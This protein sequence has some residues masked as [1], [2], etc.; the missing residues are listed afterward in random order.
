MIN[1]VMIFTVERCYITFDSVS[2]TLVSYLWHL[3]CNWKFGSFK[4]LFNLRI[5][6]LQNCLGFCHTSTW[7]S[8]RYTY[9]SPLSN[10]S[11]SPTPP[12]AYRLSRS[13][14]LEHLAPYSKFPLPMCF[15]HGNLYVSLLCSQ[16]P[17]PPLLPS[18]CPQVCSPCLCLHCC[19]ANRF[20]STIFLDSIYMHWTK[21]P[22][23]H[24]WLFV[25][26]RTVAHQLPLS[27]EFSGQEYWGRLLFSSPGNLPNPGTEPQSFA[28]PGRL[29]TIWATREAYCT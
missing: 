7:I 15:T 2:C 13:T 10:P 20:I 23:S 6:A 26:P 24:V 16:F 22:V 9:N 14:W 1:P 27:K 19:S 18:L 28:L 5:I 4:K 8:H 12:H 25:T 21:V 29:F 3:F 17:S 11:A